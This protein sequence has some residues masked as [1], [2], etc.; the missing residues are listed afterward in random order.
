MSALV[1]PTVTGRIPVNV[2]T[3]R[4]R[5]LSRWPSCGRDARPPLSGAASHGMSAASE[6]ADSAHPTPTDPASTESLALDR[7]LA[8]IVAQ[9]HRIQPAA[10][11]NTLTTRPNRPYRSTQEK[12]GR[13]AA[14]RRP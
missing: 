10:T 6:H 3:P 13:P 8:H 12:L 7:S 4:F 9:H 14:T 1:G 11:G 2:A 5:R